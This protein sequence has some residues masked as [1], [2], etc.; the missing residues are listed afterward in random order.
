MAEVGS[1]KLALSTGAALPFFT[2][3]EAVLYLS[4]Q[5]QTA[6]ESEPDGPQRRI[7]REAVTVAQR[8]RLPSRADAAPCQILHRIESVAKW[9]TESAMARMHAAGVAVVH[10]VARFVG[11]HMLRVSDTIMHRPI[12]MTA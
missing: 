10:G 1:L 9:S 2:F 7:S 8:R 5:R 12:T 4:G 3:R 11:P 6:F